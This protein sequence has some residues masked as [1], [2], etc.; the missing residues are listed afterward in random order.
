MCRSEMEG[1]K[2]KFYALNRKIILKLKS[3]D[4]SVPFSYVPII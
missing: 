2:V 4:I 3:Q 1:H